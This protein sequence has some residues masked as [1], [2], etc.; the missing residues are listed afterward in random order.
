MKMPKALTVMLVAVSVLT[1]AGCAAKS[2]ST[3]KPQTAAVQRGS[4]AVSTTSTGNLAFSQT[5]DLSF[6]MAGTV[7]EVTVAQGDSVI[8]GQQLARLDTTQWDK[9]VKTLQKALTT[10]QRSLAS[11]QRQVTTNDLAVRQAE[12]NLLTSQ[13]SLKQNLVVK[14]AQDA[15]DSLANNLDIAQLSYATNP[16]FWGPQI[17][18]FRAQLTEAH[19]PSDRQGP[20]AG[21]TECGAT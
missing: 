11:A 19:G 5:A 13:N 20:V 15:I 21:R 4:I 12:L 14:T 7:E 9:Q 3:A 8:E 10:A 16:L 1:L 17:D 6:D 2:N 18:S